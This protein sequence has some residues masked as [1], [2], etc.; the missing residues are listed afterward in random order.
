MVMHT[1]DPRFHGLVL[2]VEGP[3]FVESRKALSLNPHPEHPKPLLIPC[4]KPVRA[5]PQCMGILG[6]V[7]PVM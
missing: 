1:K 2:W 7:Q 5:P 3:Y 6:A 4:P